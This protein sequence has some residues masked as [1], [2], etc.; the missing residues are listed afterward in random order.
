MKNN[1]VMVI[2]KDQKSINQNCGEKNHVWLIFQ[3]IID[4]IK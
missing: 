3:L 4:V 2:F 1:K